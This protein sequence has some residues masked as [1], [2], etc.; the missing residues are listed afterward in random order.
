[1]SK[2][3]SDQYQGKAY[4]YAEILMD[5]G[6]LILYANYRD[7]FFLIGTKGGEVCLLFLT[8]QISSST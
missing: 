6:G 1:M 8:W 3:T 5:M 4:N 7:R 2:P